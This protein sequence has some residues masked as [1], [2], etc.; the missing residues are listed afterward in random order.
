MKT[1]KLMEP[2]Y[3]ATKRKRILAFLFSEGKAV[4]FVSIDLKKDLYGGK[5]IVIDRYAFFYD[6]SKAY[7]LDGVYI[8]VVFYDINT[9]IPI[10]TSLAYYVTLLR[11]KGIENEE[12]LLR[13]IKEVTADIDERLNQCF[14]ELRETNNE[15]VIARLKEEIAELVREKAN[16]LSKLN[17]GGLGKPMPMDYIKSYLTFLKPEMLDSALRSFSEAYVEQK[18]FFGI[19]ENIKPLLPI[20]IIGILILAGYTLF[21][22]KA[23]ISELTQQLAQC[24]Y[25]LGL[26]QN[27][28]GPI[29]HNQTQTQQPPA[30][31]NVII[32]P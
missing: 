1:Y 23:Q 26:Y 7:L 15:V 8:P 6:P 25:N 21:S 22:E 27:I 11:E 5:V 18:G 3:Q 4:K 14:K 9:A 10:D 31:G 30:S 16:R 29:Q 28:Y 2:L 24:N 17:L 20:I 12:D 32:L 13:K 19:L